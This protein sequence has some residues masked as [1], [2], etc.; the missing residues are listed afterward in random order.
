M[1]NLLSTQ[2]SMVGKRNLFSEMEDA[3]SQLK[4]MPLRQLLLDSL[5]TEQDS[6][7]A[8]ANSFERITAQ[9]QPLQIRRQFFSSWQR[10]NN[11]VMSVEGLANRITL[12][13]EKALAKG[14]NESSVMHFFRSAAQLNRVADED[15]GAKGQP[16][17][18]EL[19]YR[20]ATEFCGE[21]DTWQSHSFCLPV[22]T[23]FKSWLDSLRLKEPIM[24]GIFSMLI[25]EG[26]T[27][28]ELEIIAPLFE[29]WAMEGMK[30][31]RNDAL[32][33]TA[34][35]AVHNGGT[36]KNHFAHS[37]NAFQY[38]SAATNTKIDLQTAEQI[39]KEYLR[40]KGDVM[41]QLN[42]LF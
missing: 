34:W 35:I 3:F 25:H 8:I 1:S 36:E 29:R 41:K 7:H 4:H 32:R 2:V 42:Q 10:T 23:E 30:F 12:E 22:A 37:C 14:D 16:L 31:D 21:D 5:Q 20:M 38:Y 33:N 6:V 39:F 15:L 17:H 18:F 40:R 13:A 19:Y 26:Y 9:K 24:Y 27:H 11:S 28:A